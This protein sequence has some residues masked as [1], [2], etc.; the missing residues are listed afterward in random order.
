MASC[1]RATNISLRSTY[2]FVF[3]GGAPLNASHAA[4]CMTPS[5]AANLSAC[6]VCYLIAAV[7]INKLS[8]CI[9]CWQLGLFL[10]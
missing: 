7:L 5:S 1:S 10:S 8:G 6:E 9:R 4:S 3:S 2:G